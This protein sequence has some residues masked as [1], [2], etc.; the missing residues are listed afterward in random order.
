M[1]IIPAIP[2]KAALTATSSLRRILHVR[3]LFTMAIETIGEA[4]GLGWRVH[5]R[6]AWGKRGDEIDQGMREGI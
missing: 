4:L 3:Y 1:A 6:C 2:N 5:V